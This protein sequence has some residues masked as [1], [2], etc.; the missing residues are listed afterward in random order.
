MDGYVAGADETEKHLSRSLE[1]PYYHR[2]RDGVGIVDSVERQREHYGQIPRAKSARGR[3][4]Y[5]QRTE[6]KDYQTRQKSVGKIGPHQSS[7]KG[8]SKEAEICHQ[9][10]GY[11][12]QESLTPE[13]HLMLHREQYLEALPQFPYLLSDTQHNPVVATTAQNP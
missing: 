4:G 3:N 11:P 13:K 2:I 12:Y 9:E 5:A 7:R 1:R 6:D 8:E 10:V